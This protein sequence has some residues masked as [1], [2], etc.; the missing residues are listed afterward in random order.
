MFAVVRQIVAPLTPFVILVIITQLSER[1]KASL[2]PGASR[3]HIY[4]QPLR[5]LA[6]TL[7][8]GFRPDAPRAPAEAYRQCCVNKEIHVD[9]A[10]RR[11]G[12][13][14]SSPRHLPHRMKNL[15]R[16][17]EFRVNIERFEIVA[18]S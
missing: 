14:S 5:V 17:P 7:V 2:P 16:R 9:R 3:V 4:D 1:A 15:I 11:F 18:A 12:G 6:Y 10:G 8:V 13:L